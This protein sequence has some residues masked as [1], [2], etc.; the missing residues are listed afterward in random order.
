L[1]SRSE[2]LT[3]IL[4]AVE[5]GMSF[6][7]N[8]DDPV[9][10][11]AGIMAFNNVCWVLGLLAVA[12]SSGTPAA[13]LGT[14]S[15]TILQAHLSRLMFPLVT[16]CNLVSRMKGND[17]ELTFQNIAICIGRLGV[18]APASVGVVLPEVLGRL[19][20]AMLLLDISDERDSEFG[21]TWLGLL[22]SLNAAPRALM[23]SA[24]AE[25][26][27]VELCAG[28]VALPL[29]ADQVEGLLQAG[30]QPWVVAPS[31]LVAD[32]D[33]NRDIASILRA[34]Q[35]AHPARFAAN[36]ALQPLLAAFL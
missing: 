19:L 29:P 30:S 6:F 13:G 35:Q 34:L 3:A 12:S 7:V 24:R 1:L 32:A 26:A 36:T 4:A 8:C 18:V 20:K 22:A 25:A 10:R 15:G 17:A 2:H 16:S 23:S 21:H 5:E 9:E 31:L 27:F 14:E 11:E 28:Q 33:I